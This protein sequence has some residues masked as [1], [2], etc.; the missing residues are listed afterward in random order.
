VSLGGTFVLGVDELGGVDQVDGLIV[1][2]AFFGALQI[3]G[4]SFLVNNLGRPFTV[5]FAQLVVTGV[6]GLGLGLILET[7][8]LASALAAWREIAYTGVLSGGVAFTL[9]SVAQAHTPPSDAAIIISM[10]S[11]FAASFGALILA[12]D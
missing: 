11:V 4:V 9:Q 1:V 8:S 3:L 10:E 12:R 6:L 5:A 7:P 2:A